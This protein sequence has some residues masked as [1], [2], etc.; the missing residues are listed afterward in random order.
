MMLV[1]YLQ[2]QM[3]LPNYQDKKLIRREDLALVPD[4]KTFLHDERLGQKEI[5]R[6]KKMLTEENLREFLNDP[7]TIKKTSVIDTWMNESTEN[8][9]IVME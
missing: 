9:K 2:S 6:F 1:N 3:L 7:K 4:F 8:R 5:E